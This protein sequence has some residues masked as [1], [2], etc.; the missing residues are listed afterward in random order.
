VVIDTGPDPAPMRRCLDQ[1]GVRVVPLLVL[2]HFHADHVG[3]LAGVL[4]GRRVQRLWTSPYPSPPAEAAAVR[5]TAADDR[6]PVDV[7]PV[8]T[9]V[10]VGAVDIAVIGPVDRRATPLLSDDGQSSLENDLSLTAMI[11]VDGTRVLFSGDL[12]PEEQ[13]RVL[14]TGTDL[15]ADVL[16]VP[17]HGSSRQDPAFIAATGAR[18]AIA[19]AGVDNSYGHPAPRTMRLLEGDGMTAVC[20]CRLGSVAVTRSGG[21]LTMVSQR[22]P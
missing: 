12:E 6:I 15:H 18:L 17:H 2:T 7:P 3:G 20:T 1:L 13:R 21:R 19:S 22:G 11:T 14:A 10:R 5:R 4:R 16:K 9:H 8:G